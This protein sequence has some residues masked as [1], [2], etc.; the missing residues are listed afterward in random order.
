MRRSAGRGMHLVAGAAGPSLPAFVHMKKMEIPRATSEIRFIRCF[1]IRKRRLVMAA[2]AE[3]IIA[4]GKGGV[5]CRRIVI[6]QDPPVI[7]PMG[8]MASDAV[9]GLGRTMMVVVRREKRFHI[10]DRPSVVGQFFIVATEAKIH[11]RRRKKPRLI[12]VVG[13]VAVHAGLLIGHGAMFGDR[14][15]CQVRFIRMANGAEPGD[16]IDQHGFVR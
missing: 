1:Q 6:H 9:A 8:I 7:G 12:R 5:E 11:L 14:F 3:R 4:F 16:C 13:I 10:N 2:E 15:F